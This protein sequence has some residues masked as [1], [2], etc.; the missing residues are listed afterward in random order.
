MHLNQIMRQVFNYNNNSVSIQYYRPPTSVNNQFIPFK[1]YNTTEDTWGVLINAAAHKARCMFA[2]PFDYDSNMTV[3]FVVLPQATVN[4]MNFTVS[5]VDANPIGGAGIN[6]PYGA[7]Y[8]INN[9]TTNHLY[10]D[11]MSITF[12]HKVAKQVFCV[13]LG[14]SSSQYVTNMYACGLYFSYTPTI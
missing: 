9:A 10:T 11:D 1:P 12:Q 6:G 4:P 13:E 2:L 5:I 14:Y 8:A 3:Y 7:S